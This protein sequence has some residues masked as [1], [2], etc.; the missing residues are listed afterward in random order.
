MTSPA[1]TAKGMILGTAACMSPEQARGRAVDRRTDIWAFGCVLFEMLTGQKAFPGDT[2]TD[3]LGAVV[4]AE[5]EWSLL[6]ASMPPNV[7][8]RLKRSLHK[9]ATKRL[10]DIGDAIADLEW[11][12]AESVVPRPA[13]CRRGDRGRALS[14]P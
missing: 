3:V 4:R 8:T 13:R 1:M 10:R 11:T 14:P 6:P 9:D 2:V 12:G 5:P 7:L